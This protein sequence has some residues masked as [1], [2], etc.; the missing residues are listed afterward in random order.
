MGYWPVAGNGIRSWQRAAL[1]TYTKCI[2]EGGRT[3]LWEATPG[4]GKTRASLIAA[5]R[6]FRAGLSRRLLIVVPTAHL[7]TQWSR[8]AHPF[9]FRLSTD[10]SPE[11]TPLAPDYHGAVVTYQQIANQPGAFRSFIRGGMTILDEV[12]HSADGRTWGDSLIQALSDAAFILCLSG[13]AFRSDDNP[14][15]F[16]KYSKVGESSPDYTY[17]YAQAVRDG[18][19][20][21]TAFFAYGGEVAWSFSDNVTQAGF[22]DNLDKQDSARRLRAA[23]DPKSG[24]LEPL[25]KDANEMLQKV[26]H[27][28]PNAGGLLVAA[29]QKHAR[30]FAGVLRSITGVQP[31]VVLSDD[32]TASEKIKSFANSDSAWLVACNMVSEGVDIPRLRVGVYGTTIRTRMYFRQFLGRIIRRT[33]DPTGVQIA[34]CYLPADPRLQ[35]HAREIEKE[36]RHILKA[37]SNEDLFDMLRD[38]ERDRSEKEDSFTSVH[39]T[40]SGLQTV[41]VNG[42]QLSLFGDDPGSPLPERLEQVVRQEVHS[43]LDRTQTHFELKKTLSIDIK[44]LVTM[45]QKRSGKSHSAIHSFL[46]RKQKVKS[47]AE[48]AMHQLEFRIELL[49]KLLQEKKFDFC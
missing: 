14:I 10:F 3:L 26:R 25:L 7:K 40:N 33:T 13:T 11:V 15:P 49:S 32:A 47:Q 5:A 34:Y 31:V 2:E 23:L 35:A 18:V 21:P 46:N 48:C 43:Q 27:T 36:Q 38:I 4:S 29:N 9:N 28:H 39:A 44:N 42:G 24:W 6:Q 19:C 20:R 37:K 41:I 12:H 45:L 17:Q 1:L 22:G 30:A 8:A 16:V